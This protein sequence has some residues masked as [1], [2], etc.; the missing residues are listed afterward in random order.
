MLPHHARLVAETTE[1]FRQDP[2]VQGLLVG[3]SVAHGLARPD[4]DLDVMVVVADDELARRTGEHRV[5]FF[6]QDV[7]GAEGGDLDGKLISRELI[8]AVAERGSEPARW[9]FADA[10]VAFARDPELAWFVEAAGRYPEPERDEKLR[11]FVGHA[12]LMRWFQA[13][14]ERRSDRYLAAY[15]ASRL[16]LYAGR[17]IL[18]HNR[19]LYPFHKWFLTILERAPSRPPDLLEL[20]GAVLDEPTVVNADRLLEPVVATVGVE[21]TPAEAA[22]RFTERTEW[23]WRFGRPPLDDS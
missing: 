22:S 17:A 7:G 5:V 12:Q 8:G 2:A 10:I 16:V 4:S 1:R 15:A 9:A 11:D 6:E 14:A 18:A 21:V 3:G 23:S 20:I 13:Q 19:M